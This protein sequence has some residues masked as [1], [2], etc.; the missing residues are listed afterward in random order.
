[1]KQ[2]S[3]CRLC[4]AAGLMLMLATPF[5]IA[6]QPLSWEQTKARFE[7][8]NPALKADALAVDEAHAG[9]I[10]A[11]LR[12][13]PQFTLSTDGTQIAPHNGVWQPLVGTDIVP[14]LSYLHERAHKRELRLESA[15]EGT[16]IAAATHE[17][18][19]RSLEFT[20]RTAFIG[21]L[22]AKAVLSLAES[23]LDYYDKIIAI[24]SARL[25]DG[26]LAQVDFDRIE[27]LRAPYEVEIANA[28]VSLRT[29]KI[30]LEQL[31]NERTPVEQFDVTGPFDFSEAAQSLEEVRSAALD[32]RPDLKAALLAAE[33]AQTNYKL[34]VANGS[35]DPTVSGWYTWN[36]SNNNANANQT[37][38]MSVNIPLRLFDHNQG[39]K[40]RA[41][42]DIGRTQQTSEAVRAQVFS[43][44]DSAYAQVQSDIELLRPYRDKYRGQAIRVRDTV[45]YS[46]QH[47]AASL[48][49]FL[50]AQR[51][52]RV[53]QL[54][55]LQLVGSY[56]T[57]AAQLNLSVGREV[58]P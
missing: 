48:M 41:R 37:L 15:R 51:D 32:A 4:P 56:M 16:R 44:V 6:Q 3:H 10:T 42:I 1:M 23:D 11:N 52:Y 55:Y 36:A 31:L 29:A 7:T 28:R 47:G 20:L 46:Y 2:Q 22:E 39:E 18:L 9:E 19:R 5:A 54:S 24:S 57:A 30:Q 38:G 50:D 33:Q 21:V 25:K 34:A 13:N 12:P 43:D 35:T 45:T 53:I 49:E 8:N 27:L 26:D 40:Q 58:L 14:T 17:D